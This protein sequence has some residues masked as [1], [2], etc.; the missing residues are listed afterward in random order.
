[1]IVETEA[2]L[3]VNDKAAHAYGGRRTKRVETMYGPPGRAYVYIIYGMYNCLNTITREEGVPQG[4]LIRGI[5]PIEGLDYMALNRFNKPLEELTK[6]QIKNLTNGPGKLCQAMMIDR[7]LDKEDLCGERLY[8]EKG[9]DRNFD[10]VEAKRIGIDYAEEA[11]DFLYRFYI[12][13]NPN[14]SKF[15]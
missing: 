13:G 15:K 3:G 8:I 10:I 4:V 2:Y 12:E 1:M 14:V 6:N 7:S 9:I 11:R 5:E